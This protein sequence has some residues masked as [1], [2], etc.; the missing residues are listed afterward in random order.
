MYYIVGLG[1]PGEEYEN[2]RHNTGR[3]VLAPF[4]KQNG[5]ADL[6][7]SKKTK[8]LESTGKVADEKVTVIFP[9]TYM[10]K[11]GASL[12]SHITNS[13]KAQNL[14][15]VYDDLDLPL[16]T[17]KISYNRS[18]GGHRGLESIIRVLKTTEFIRIRVGISPS[19]PSGKLK[20]PKGETDVE[21]WIIGE[22]KPKEMDELKKIS[23]RV[24]TALSTIIE[25]GYERAMTEC[26]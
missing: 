2:T 20:K 25:F 26:N 24:A 7:L 16:G 5:F 23:K 22:F 13:K 15:V 21:K 4:L 19:T 18:S 9:E 8:A 10:N 17:I 6:V 1:N 14:V 11:S 12:L 3:L